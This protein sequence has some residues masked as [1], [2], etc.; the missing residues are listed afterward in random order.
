MGFIIT[1]YNCIF[2][3]LRHQS[4]IL[5]RHL[6][7]NEKGTPSHGAARRALLSG[8][9]GEFDPEL[10]YTQT[11]PV[12]PTICPVEVP[13][14]P[15]QVPRLDLHFGRIWKDIYTSV[16]FHRLA[17]LARLRYLRLKAVLYSVRLRA[18]DMKILS[19]SLISLCTGTLCSI[20]ISRA[21]T[22]RKS[23]DNSTS[24]LVPRLCTICRVARPS[25]GTHRR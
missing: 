12:P 24:R 9:E 18:P 13:D 22:R 11:R 14:R 20:V 4:Y 7:V 17:P 15:A 1:G 25:A 8:A 21:C 10:A 6:R 3:P 5:N 23:W 19:S 2:L 16:S